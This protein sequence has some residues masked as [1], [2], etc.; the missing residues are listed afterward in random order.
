MNSIA[1]QRIVVPPD[2][3]GPA[4]RLFMALVLTGGGV[5]LIVSGL[6]A[7]RLSAIL[8]GIGLTVFFGF[9]AATSLGRLLR[10]R[11][12]L[13]VDREGIVLDDARGGA[14]RIGWTD[15]VSVRCSRR[16]FRRGVLL[17][18]RQDGQNEVRSEVL[19]R[20][21]RLGGAPPQWVAGL[22]ETFRLRP[23]LRTRLAPPAGNA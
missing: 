21:E 22:I 17:G 10:T 8:G 11:P 9:A 6:L 19:L 2:R 13:V 4:L 1:P 20:A 7:G 12:F 14:L 15:L 3:L 23:D 5:A 16:P 18:L